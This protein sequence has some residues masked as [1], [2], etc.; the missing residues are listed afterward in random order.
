[1]A[2]AEKKDKDKDKTLPREQFVWL[3]LCFEGALFLVAAV[4]AWG[5]ELPL[6][7]QAHW[8]WSH[9][10]WGLL[11]TLPPLAAMWWLQHSRL[12]PLKRLREAVDALVMPLFA[13]CNWLDFL[14]ISLMAGLG[15]EALFRGVIQSPLTTYLPPWVAIA[16]GA[17]LFGLVHWITF[18]Y[19]V[20][21]AILG[22]YLGWLFWH[23]ENLLVPMIVHALYDFAAL[24]Y[25]TYNVSPKTEN[26]AS[27]A[28][29]K[30][31]HED[32]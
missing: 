23:F 1:M 26:D 15:E 9:A 2:S 32:V 17:I 3:A 27:S 18:S 4:L 13:Q 20:F 29:S 11:A 30:N 12:P 8:I 16:L 19:A 6:R 5:F 10:L 21:A 22:A 31:A 24:V 14:L 7:N 25:L 28:V